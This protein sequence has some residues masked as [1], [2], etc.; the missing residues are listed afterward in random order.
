MLIKK[1]VLDIIWFVNDETDGQ[2]I[3]WTQ[4]SSITIVS[5]AGAFNH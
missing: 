2:L 4:V 3:D 5:Y 1:N